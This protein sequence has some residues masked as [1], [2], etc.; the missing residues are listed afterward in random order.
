M[1]AGHKSFTLAA[2]NESDMQDWLSKLQSVLNQNKM[3]DADNR[4]A[5]LEREKSKSSIK[6]V[7]ERSFKCFSL[8][9]SRKPK[10]KSKHV[11]NV[12]RVG[13]IDESP[14]HEIWTRN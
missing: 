1:T 9:F 11:W 6:L 13:P 14:A 10:S 7:N 2:D 4:S 12:E 8:L 3:Q 5:S